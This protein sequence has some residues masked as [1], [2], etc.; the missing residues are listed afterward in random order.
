MHDNINYN[1]AINKTL[2]LTIHSSSC[3]VIK[4]KD[5]LFSVAVSVSVF[6]VLLSC[7]FNMYFQIEDFPTKKN[8]KT[9][10]E[11]KDVAKLW[12]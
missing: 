11:E 3:K 7:Q 9:A 2:D 12:S 8:L 4:K 5:I 6:F 10:C 1:W